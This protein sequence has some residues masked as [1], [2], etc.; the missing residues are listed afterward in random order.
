MQIAMTLANQ[1]LIMFLLMGVGIFSYKLKFFTEEGIRDLNNFLVVVI[2]IAAILDPFTTSDYSP[3]R[4]KNLIIASIL[5]LF[6]N[7]VGILISTLAYSTKNLESKISIL[8][9]VYP[10]SGFMA[11]PLLSAVFGSEGVFYGAIYIAIFNIFV[12]AHLVPLLTDGPRQPAIQYVKI[13][14]KNPVIIAI[15]VSIFL[16]VMDIKFPTPIATVVSYISGLNTPIAMMLLG[17]FVCKC[18]VLKAFTNFKIYTVCAMKLVVLPLIFL[19]AMKIVTLFYP[20]DQTVVVCL[21]IS[22]GAPTAGIVTI[23]CERLGNDIEYSI[24]IMTLCTLLSL[25]SLPFV[26]YL[27]QT[28]I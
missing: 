12:W 23:M 24:Q 9:S 3:E 4:V 2:V 25:F 6:F 11:L 8:A 28:I 17:M 13:I 26:I 22:S 14:A 21:L 7:L 20:L 27:A 15:I 16:Y 5:A 1:I 19:V 10:N 18:N